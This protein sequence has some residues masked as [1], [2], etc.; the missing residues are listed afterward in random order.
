MP[1]YAPGVSSTP[2]PNVVA[3]ESAPS[4]PWNPYLLW[5][6]AVVGIILVLVYIRM[7]RR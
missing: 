6:I 3:V 2:L 7:K 4:E 5:I 1:T